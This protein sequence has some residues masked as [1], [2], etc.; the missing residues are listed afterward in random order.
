MRDAGYIESAELR[1]PIAPA[2]PRKEWQALDQQD[3]V[4]ALYALI[5][6]LNLRVAETLVVELE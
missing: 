1:P 4:T 2:T 3:D 6:S 5:R